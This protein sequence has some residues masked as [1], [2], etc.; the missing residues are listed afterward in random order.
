M[1]SRSGQEKITFDSDLFD[2][3]TRAARC[4][5]WHDALVWLT[6]VSAHSDDPR[7]GPTCIGVDVYR[8]S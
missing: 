2:C 7:I 3:T 6:G 5:D 4:A 8:E 1:L